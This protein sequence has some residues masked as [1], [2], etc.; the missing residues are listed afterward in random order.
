M[1][2]RPHE[3]GNIDGAKPARRLDRASMEPRPHERGNDS[4][5]RIASA[6]R[7]A[8]MEPRPH[9][10]GNRPRLRPARGRISSFNGA[11]SSRT[12]KPARA[13]VG[14][15]NRQSFN[16]ATSSRTWKRMGGACQP[17]VRH[18]ASMEPRPHER[19]NELTDA[20]V[21]SY[22]EAS[23]EPRPHERGN[24][25]RSKRPKPTT[26]PL[27][28]SHVLTNVETSLFS[29]LSS[30]WRLLQ[31]SHVLTNVETLLVASVM[32]VK[33]KKSFNGATSSRTWKRG[34][35]QSVRRF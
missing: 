29:R 13:S 22:G 32:M 18:Q 3:R 1:E 26:T 10:R 19:G 15:A 17:K 20:K 6:L 5:R 16:G 2:P 25:A 21:G 12:W 24:R 28:W 14:Q 33:R 4:S 9:E 34:S 23:M 27:Q 35:L 31:W 30:N 8:S 7:E 11:T